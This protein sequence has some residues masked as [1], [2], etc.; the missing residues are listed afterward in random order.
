MIHG[1]DG[2]VTGGYPII[3]GV[4]SADLHKFSLWSPGTTIAFQPVCREEAVEAHANLLKSHHARLKKLE[5][6]RRI[7][8][9]D[10]R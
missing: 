7:H 6:A 3:G 8:L 1:P 9:G 4:I 5:L 10:T 2:P